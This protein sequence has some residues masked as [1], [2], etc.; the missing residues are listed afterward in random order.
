MFNSS[1]IKNENIRN[2]IIINQVNQLLSKSLDYNN[3]L[4]QLS[5]QQK[6]LTRTPESQ[7]EE[8]QAISKKINELKDLIEQFRRDVLQLAHIFQ[9]SDVNTERLKRAQAFFDKGEFSEARAVL[10]N[11]LEQMQAEQARL[12]QERQRYENEILPKLKHNSEE[13]YILALATQFDYDNPNRLEDSCR[14][15]DLSIESDKGAKGGLALFAY[16]YFL[17]K[18]NKI[19][20]ANFWAERKESPKIIAYSDQFINTIPHELSVEE[21]AKTL[22]N[23]AI[24]HANQNEDDHALTKFEEALQLHRELAKDNATTFLP[25]VAMILHT[26][27]MFHF[28]CGDVDKALQEYEA[29]LETH[30]YL[31]NETSRYLFPHMP[32]VLYDMAILN[33]VEN[34][35]E[36][37]LQESEEAL[38]YYRY[39]ADQISPDFL[40]DVAKTLYLLSILYAKQNEYEKAAQSFDE[41]LGIYRNLAK[42]N[43]TDFLPSV[44]NTLHHSAILHYEQN[45]YEIASKRFEEALYLRR[46]FARDNPPALPDVAKTLH[47]LADL[48]GEQ[49]HYEL[50]LQ[51]YEEVLEINRNL[52]KQSPN[53]YASDLSGILVTIATFCLRSLPMRDKS[54]RYAVEALSLLSMLRGTPPDI[55][56]I[57]GK[58]KD[59]LRNWGLS[60][61]EVPYLIKEKIRDKDQ[62]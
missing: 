4:D 30:R 38:R 1:E 47:K 6:L 46:F 2:S 20:Q 26:R 43:P 56:E 34:K 13:F 16:S 27:G 54:I 10:A 48:H 22:Y 19:P 61:E 25:E 29:A 21:T 31:V 36:E 5:T 37:A 59:I 17:A 14:Y 33:F 51:E 57:E 39:L 35:Y 18:R 32:N 62:P 7:S 50:A 55:Q 52:Y 58:A 40:G 44:A 23:M 9:N 24:L 12:L 49:G 41:T 28:A 3:L 53:N 45:K 11:D 15:F 8:R 42:D 60:E